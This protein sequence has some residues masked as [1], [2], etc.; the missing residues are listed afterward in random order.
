MALAFTSPTRTTHITGI[1]NL[2]HEKLERNLF[3]NHNYKQASS[4]K[5]QVPVYLDD[6]NKKPSSVGIVGR[7]FISVLTAKLAALSGY[8]T[9]ILYPPSELETMKRLIE[10]P[11]LDNQKDS[12]IVPV[13]SNLEFL[14]IA[15]GDMVQDR[16]KETDALIFAVDEADNGVLEASVINFLINQDTTSTQRLKKV[17][18]MS[19]NLNGQGMGFVVKAAKATANSEI[20]SGDGNQI[21]KYKLFE[22]QVNEAISSSL[23]ANDIDVNIVR[24]GTLKGGGCGDI[25]SDEAFPKYLSPF[26][27]DLTKKD[28]ITW[29]LLFDCNVRGVKLYKGDTMAGPGGKAILTAT[30]SDACE[31]DSSR[32]AV[33]EALV[34]SLNIQGSSEFAVGTVERRTPLL[35]SEWE[36]IL[37][38]VV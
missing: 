17:A 11:E 32:C 1:K 30:S 5:A 27:Y 6:S 18:M 16:M 2:K 26:F 37:E 20:W 19:R 4:L 13:P 23:N 10:T 22:K 29:Q 12:D 31:G 28:I 7:G 25:N 33:A 35:D 9:W 36:K 34:K 21:K 38:E 24:A 3:S 15:D 14:S 8:Q